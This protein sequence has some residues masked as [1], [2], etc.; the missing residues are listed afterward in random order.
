MDAWLRYM[1]ENPGLGV[2]VG[3]LNATQQ[4]IA[5]GVLRHLEYTPGQALEVGYLVQ[6]EHRGMGIATE[7]TQ[8]LTSYAFANFPDDQV[9]AVTSP[10]NLASQKVLIK[11]GFKS[12]G[13]R[14]IY[15]D[16]CM[17]FA[18]ARPA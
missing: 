16:V 3:L 14:E 11:C 12:V 1:D 4:P 17:E 8:M 10:E 5:T 9:L 2:W 6:R 13:E 15:G 7:I 18:L